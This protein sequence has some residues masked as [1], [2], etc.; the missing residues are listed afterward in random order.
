[1]VLEATV[2]EVEEESK[3][4]KYQTKKRCGE[5]IRWKWLIAENDIWESKENLKESSGRI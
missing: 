5:K 4:R 2:I 3:L 1:L